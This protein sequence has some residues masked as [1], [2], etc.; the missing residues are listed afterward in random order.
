MKSLAG[1]TAVITGAGSGIGRALALELARQ[2]CR[3]ALVER[4]GDAL[5]QTQAL[6]REA[7][8]RVS[9]HLVDVSHKKSMEE[10]P[11]EVLTHHPAVDVVI[12]NAGVAVADTFMRGRLEDFEWLMGVNFWG[13]VYGCKFFLPYLKARPEALLANMS[14][15]WGLVGVASS[16]YYCAA[17]HA[18]L[19]FSESLRLELANTNIQ[20]STILP[21]GVNTHIVRNTRF[22]HHVHGLSHE[23]AVQR[24]AAGKI[25]TPEAAAR[26]IIDGLIKGRARILVG[27]DAQLLDA[28]RRLFPT[29]YERVLKLLLPSRMTNKNFK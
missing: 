8:A 11:E 6:V 1:K 12:N 21:G 20:V 27:R 24:F 5:S 9:A 15:V 14:S 18:V 2:N 4:D 28:V 10:L 3:L 22:H 19:G 17:K 7:G 23:Q 13:V 16:N 25:L 26:I 29:N